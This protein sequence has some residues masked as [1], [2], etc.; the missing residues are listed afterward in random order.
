MPGGGELR[1]VGAELGDDDPGVAFADPGD[2]IQPPGQPQRGRARIGAAGSVPAAHSAGGAAR[3]GARDSRQLLPDRLVQ[4]GDLLVDRVDQPQV[5]FDLQRVNVAEPAGQRVL[6]L[7]PGGLQPYVSQRGQR[8]R[9]ALPGDQ[10]VQEPRPLAPNRS[11][12][13]TE[14]FSSDPLGSLHPGPV[15]R[16]V[17]GQPGPGAGQR[18]QVLDRLRRHERAAQHRPLVQLA[19]PHAVGAVALARLG[20]CLTSRAL[21]SHTSSPAASA[22]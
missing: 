22:R 1:R 2:L 20:R 5:R 7:P 3:R 9:A 4:P 12:I 10:G 11:E 17:L 19:V 18:P 8:R 13:T 21:P 15:P 16:L 14:I 6:Q